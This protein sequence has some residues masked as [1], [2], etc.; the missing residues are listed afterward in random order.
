MRAIV[1]RGGRALRPESVP[2]PR[3]GTGQV[4]VRVEV[5]AICG[6]D[7]HLQEFGA[8][9]PV[10]PGHEAAGVVVEV[11]PGVHAPAVGRRVT[12]DPVQRCGVC[13]PCKSGMGH[14]CLDTRHLGWGQCAGTWAQLVAVDAVNAHPI[15]DAVSFAEASLCEPAS[16]CYESFQRARLEPG[17][18]VLVIGDGPFGFLHAQWARTL[19]ARPIVVLGHHDARLQRIRATTGAVVCNTR[20]EDV[21]RV[22]SDHL[23]PGADV[24]VEAT[25]ASASP[26]LGISLL[27][28]RG[29]LVIF[30]YVWEPRPLDLGAIHMKEL[31]LMGSCRSLEAFPHSIRMIA[32]GRLDTRALI[33]ETLPLEQLEEGLRMLDQRK[34]ELFKVA[35]TPGGPA[36]S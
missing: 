3:P 23:G 34:G 22:A 16:V 2:E 36:D 8:T 11:G 4:L 24:V 33:G 14:L 32:E 17:Q 26:G 28:P 25:G 35:L 27:R 29:T 7:L 6:S 21:A 15:P 9:P 30:S 20:R 10:I 12:L 13:H 5:T 19:G 18:S 1:W 31:C